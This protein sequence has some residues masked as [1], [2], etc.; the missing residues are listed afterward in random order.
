ML[1][2]FD[3]M[4][5]AGIQIQQ[6]IV[7]GLMDDTADAE[8]AMEKLAKKLVRAFK[9]ALKIKSP[10]RVF[11]AQAKQVLAGINMGL[12]DTSSVERATTRVADNMVAAFN[13]Y[14]TAT[15]GAGMS[16]AGNTYNVTVVTPP[17]PDMVQFGI[18]AKQAIK[19]AERSG[20]RS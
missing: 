3:T 20:A 6:G 15:A 13:P 4:N 11:A 2:R 19:E 7:N 10:S 14:L 18:V 17:N 1:F 16:A 9:K 12:A 5:S 8:E